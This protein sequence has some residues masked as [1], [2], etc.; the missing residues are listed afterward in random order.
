MFRGSRQ[1]R[2]AEAG[3]AAQKQK[4]HFKENRKINDQSGLSFAGDVSGKASE[5]LYTQVEM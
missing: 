3:S 2:E 4:D 5:R 1:K